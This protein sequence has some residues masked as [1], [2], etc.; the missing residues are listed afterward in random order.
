M[1]LKH[2]T[3]EIFQSLHRCKPQ[4]HTQHFSIA[5]WAYN[6]LPPAYRLFCGCGLLLDFVPSTSFARPWIAVHEDRAIVYSHAE[7]AAMKAEVDVLKEAAEK[8]ELDRPVRVIEPTVAPQP[9]VDWFE[10]FA[11][12]ILAF[13]VGMHAGA[14]TAS[15]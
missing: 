14:H 15:R 7:V 4:E 2:V 5:A 11:W 3:L 9:K 6:G 13:I 1:T 8:L 12:L 10:I